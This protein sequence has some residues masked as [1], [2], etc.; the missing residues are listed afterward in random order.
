MICLWCRGWVELWCGYKMSYFELIL[1]SNL[2]PHHVIVSV[3]VIQ[4][5]AGSLRDQSKAVFL[6]LSY[7][8]NQTEL[9]TILNQLS[10]KGRALFEPRFHCIPLPLHPHSFTHRRC[11]SQHSLFSHLVYDH[12]PNLPCYPHGCLWRGCPSITTKRMRPSLMTHLQVS[13]LTTWCKGFLQNEKH[14]GCSMILTINS[15]MW[16]NKG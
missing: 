12:L 13:H 9:H 3:H 10:H 6:C 16:N 1:A 11:S 7:F 8:Y 4:S 5:F 15:V 14:T 2:S